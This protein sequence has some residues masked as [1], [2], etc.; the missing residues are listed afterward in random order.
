M[1]SQHLHRFAVLVALMAPLAAGP[2]LAQTSGDATLPDPVVMQLPGA[3]R[4]GADPLQLLR[5]PQVRQEL[6][7]SD[8]QMQQLE[9]LDKDIRARVR[10]LSA[11]RTRG[12]A[13][14]PPVGAV[15][16]FEADQQQAAREARQR[17]AEILTPEQLGA[18][19]AIVEANP[20][21]DPLQLLLSDGARVRLGLSAGQT[22]QLRQLASR[23]RPPEGGR[24]RGSEGNPVAAQSRQLESLTRSTRATVASILTP[25]QLSRFRQILVQVDGAQLADPAMAGALN[26]TSE[27]QQALALDQQKTFDAI[28]DGYKAPRTRGPGGTIPC[29]VVEANR[30]RLEPVIQ[31]GQARSRGLLT[32]SQ[33]AVLQ[34]MEGEPIALTPP[35]PC[36]PK[37]VPPMQP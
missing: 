9:Q 12:G 26:L 17:V 33:L 16:G 27:Q 5:Q 30:A 3:S 15:R 32:S 24:T 34:Q 22:Q 8:A 35:E 19:R 7:L 11:P 37:A 29:P 28:G 21:T 4:P 13:A 18:F 14:A 23:M 20:G 2:L 31:Q 6:S 25:Q 1:T 10:S 36:G